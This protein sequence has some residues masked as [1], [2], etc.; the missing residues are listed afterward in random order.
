MSQGS[1]GNKS[2]ATPEEVE[3]WYKKYPD[4]NV[5]ILAD[6]YKFMY[7][8]IKPTAFPCILLVDENMRLINYTNRGL[9][10]TFL[11]LTKSTE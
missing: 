6:E 11:Y 3:A 5:P 10:E 7:G 4:P 2:T 9:V 8:W 1:D